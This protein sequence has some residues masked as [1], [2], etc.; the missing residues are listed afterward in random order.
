MIEKV[1]TFY[2]K[3]TLFGINITLIKEIN[4]N[5][6]YTSVP[7]AKPYI[8]GLF[9]MRGQIVTLFDLGK[10][11]GLPESDKSAGSACVILKYKPNDP[12]QSGFLIDRTGDVIDID[13]EECE[14][15]PANIGYLEGEYIDSVVKLSNELLILID[16]DKVFKNLV[17]EREESKC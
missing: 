3:D 10:I 13:R 14:L 6:E 12:N 16:P 4:R 11:L 7:D 9:N 8:I 5:A 2:L 17:A 1:L 15:P